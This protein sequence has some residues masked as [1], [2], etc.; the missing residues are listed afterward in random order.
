MML[1]GLRRVVGGMLCVPVRDVRV[2]RGLFVIAGYVFRIGQLLLLNQFAQRF[3]NQAE[4]RSQCAPLCIRP[5]AGHT[6]SLQVGG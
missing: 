4:A 5:L 6:G 1:G 3:G 2:M